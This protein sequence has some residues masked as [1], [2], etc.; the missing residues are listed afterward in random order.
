MRTH[1]SLPLLALASL[2]LVACSTGRLELQTNAA[3]S[4]LSTSAD[5]SAFPLGPG[6]VVRVGVFGHDEL[7][8]EG[9]RVDAEG[10]LSLPLV[11][12]VFVAGLTVG[13]ARE[14]ITSAHAEFVLEPRVEVS[15][16]EH[17]ARRFYVFGQVGTSGA[18]DLD[19]PVTVL[20][21]LALAGGLTGK[22]D[23]RQVVL[24]R[25]GPEQLEVAVID[26]EHPDSQCFLTLRSEDVLFVRRSGAAK[27]ADEILPYI[28]GISW[29]LSSV[30]TLFLID[31]QI[32]GD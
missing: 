22:A 6:D 25:G 16:V 14:S 20:Q 29:S 31:D 30:A 21:A 32:Q 15:V 26:V 9:T 5:W 19:R 1:R 24:L 12:P 10:H 11:G 7:G 2:A 17:G 13:E 3:T 8:T 27:F 4:T 18:F 23:P 28:S